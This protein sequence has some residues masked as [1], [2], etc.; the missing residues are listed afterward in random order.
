MKMSIEIITS[1]AD[2]RWNYTSQTFVLKIFKPV[3][4]NLVISHAVCPSGNLSTTVYKSF[5][6]L[7]NIKVLGKERINVIVTDLSRVLMQQ[8]QFFTVM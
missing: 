5:N 1:S 7:L 6:V 3:I 4:S 2:L 8:L